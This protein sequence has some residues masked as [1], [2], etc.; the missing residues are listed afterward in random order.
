MNCGISFLLYS[1]VKQG[2]VL[3]LWWNRY[4]QLFQKQ[5]LKYACEF[6]SH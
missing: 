6:E 4:T 3:F 5:P 2:T 1:V